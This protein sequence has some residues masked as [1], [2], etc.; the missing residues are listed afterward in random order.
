[1]FITETAHGG[2]HQQ[3]MQ[4]RRFELVADGTIDGR[5]VQEMV[6]INRLRRARIGVDALR[7]QARRDHRRM[8]E[9]APPQQAVRVRRLRAQ[10]Q[11]RRINGAARQHEVLGAQ[12][13]AHAR[14]RLPGG[15]ERRHLQ[16]V[17][18][19][20]LEAETLGARMHEQARA[21]RQRRRDRRH[22]HRLLGVGRAAHAA[23]AEVPAAVH[24][25]P[26]GG[27]GDAQRRRA[28]AQQVVVF[29]G[30]RGWSLTCRRF[31]IMANHGA[32]ASTE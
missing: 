8:Q 18:A 20:A 31:S 27:R 28:T 4:R 1:M 23:I 5:R 15:V 2:G 12:G 25:A 14:R 19:L 6:G 22:Q 21:Q 17:D 26:D 7:E 9:G 13:E 30:R 24:V 29:I 11:R 10:Q 3:R 32:M 16:A